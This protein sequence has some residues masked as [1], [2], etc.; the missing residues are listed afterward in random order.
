MVNDRYCEVLGYMRDEL[1]GTTLMDKTHPDDVEGVLANRKR[2]LSGESSAYSMEMRCVR[3]DQA[4]TWVRL[5]GSLVR[6]GEARPR[7]F[8]A[9]VADITERK[10]AE[11]ALRE[12]EERFRNMAD[13]APV[14]IWISD[15]GK[16]CTF[17]NKPWLDFTGR[18]I[19]QELGT[20]WVNGMHPEDLDRCGAI[21]Y[22]RLTPSP[23][24]MDYRLRR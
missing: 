6:D 19:E 20:G 23:F 14:M 15:L 11:A 9:V 7:Y 4:I 2:L 16:R 21:Y 17:F 18:T 24:Q 13:T 3:K 8:I 22:H 5:Y 10:Q 1:L 12:S